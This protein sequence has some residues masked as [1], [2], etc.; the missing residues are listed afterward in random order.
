MFALQRMAKTRGVRGAA[1]Q[2][3]VAAL[4]YL[5]ARWALQAFLSFLMGLRVPGAT[6]A[7]PVGYTPAAAALLAL[8]AAA[9][10][11][12]IPVAWLLF[13]TRLQPRDL[14]LLLPSQ[15]APWWCLGVFLGL[16]NLFNLVGGVLG[17]LLGH[18]PSAAVLPKGAGALFISFLGLCALPAI[19]EEL[20]FRGALQ[21][22]MRPAGSVAAILAPALLFALLHLDLFQC[23][24]AF[25][26]GLFLGWLTERTGSILPGML[27]HFVNN[28]LA[29][30]V[31]YLQLYAP[32]QAALAAQLVLLLGCP[33]VGGLLVWRA[34]QQDLR[35]E[36]GLRPGPPAAAIF[37]SPVYSVTVALLAA[38]TLYLQWGAA[39]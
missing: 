12:A 8:V 32:P 38:Y 15:W 17:R 9:G 16:A 31:L 11:L 13:A 30:L 37:G 29:F 35:F 6:L 26:C 4:G 27:L 3:A 34:I 22:L 10:A 5:L 36:A 24:T 39:A 28:C 19:G 1:G 20:L 18:G 33:V 25:A 14:R 2:C 21:G 23:L 7:T